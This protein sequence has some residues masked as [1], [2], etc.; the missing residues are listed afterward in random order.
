[1]V[2]GVTPLTRWRELSFNTDSIAFHDSRIPIIHNLCAR[3]GAAPPGVHRARMEDGIP[4]ERRMDSLPPGW[5]SPAGHRGGSGG[6][7]QVVASCGELWLAE[8]ALGAVGTSGPGAPWAGR[9]CSGGGELGE[10]VGRR[11]GKGTAPSRDSGSSAI[12][13]PGNSREG[14][15]LCGRGWGCGMWLGACPDTNGGRWEQL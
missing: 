7:W 5:A 9:G 8:L 3:R 12:P 1:M 15:T 4:W 11:A 10:S 6:L 2:E 13:S 14:L